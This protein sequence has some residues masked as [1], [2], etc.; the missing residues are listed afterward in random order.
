M[1]PNFTNQKTF[2]VPTDD[3]FLLGIL[4]CFLINVS[5]HPNVSEIAGDFYEPGWVFFKNYPIRAIDA[6]DE[7]AIQK[8]LDHQFGGNNG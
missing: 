6:S 8:E 1:K 2:I 3:L 5:F 4:E 7:V